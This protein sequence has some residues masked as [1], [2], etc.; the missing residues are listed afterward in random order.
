[1]K[2]QM[3]TFD[4]ARGIIASF[5]AAFAYIMTFICTKTYYNLETWLSLPGIS[6]LY[7][8]VAATGFVMNYF[9]LPETENRTLEEVRFPN[10]S[11]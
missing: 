8:I 5:A 2:S 11:N 9:I 3:F 10:Q 4:R 6:L 7:C 1:M